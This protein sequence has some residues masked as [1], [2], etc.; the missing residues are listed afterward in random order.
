MKYCSHCG[1]SL[2]DET[3]YC[4]QCGAPQPVA[5]QSEQVQPQPAPAVQQQYYAPQQTPAPQMWYQ[6]RNCSAV[7]PHDGTTRLYNCPVCGRSLAAAPKSQPRW[8]AG[9]IISIV[10][11]IAVFAGEFLPFLTVSA[12][13]FS[14][15]VQ[16]WSEKFLGTA[17]FITFLLACSFLLVAFDKNS[18]GK[19][20][21]VSALIILYLIYTDYSSNQ[22][23]LSNVDAGLEEWGLGKID[24]S[25]MLQPGVG[26]YIM[27]IG[28]LGMIAGAIALHM[29]HQD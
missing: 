18:K 28:C 20:A 4:I 13:G 16:V 11:M 23:R 10:S 25:G 8:A 3:A 15:S 27:V 12:L 26:L 2:P 14:Y 29:R 17:F 24:A 22:A 9:H 1:T 19:F 6:C 5:R 21:F 7:I